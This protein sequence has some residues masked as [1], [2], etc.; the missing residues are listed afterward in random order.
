MNAVKDRNELAMDKLAETNSKNPE[1][2][3]KELLS[4]FTSFERSFKKQYPII[5]WA[6]LL[7]PL[8]LS[9]V[10]LTVLGLINGW[11]Y[12]GNLVFHAMATFFAFGRFIILLGTE[13]GVAP[14][15]A[16]KV[17][18][19]L[20]KISMKP[21]ELFALV[22]CMDVMVALF[23][24]FHMGFLF[25][26][27]YVGPKIAMLVWDGK[28][29]M[30]SAPW[31]KRMAFSGLVLF[32]MFPTSTTGSIGGSIFGR[33]L[34]MSRFLTVAGVLLGSILGNAMMYVF[35]KKINQFIG[36][37]NIWVKVAGVGILLLVVILAEFRYRYVKNKYLSDSGLLNDESTDA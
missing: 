7:S 5:W 23:V 18:S 6:T 34:G 15:T 35:A 32:V 25:R 37:D 22:S 8:L 2:L 9:A 16:K 3:R 24:T 27:P 10:M 26:L 21:S 4:S 28:F 12:S 11:E 20:Y 33:L 17:T 13:S 19:W 29:I 14:D 30:D 31:L 36:P 1:L